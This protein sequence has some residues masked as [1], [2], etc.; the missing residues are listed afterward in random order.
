MHDAGQIIQ[1]DVTDLYS[2]QPRAGFSSL[3]KPSSQVTWASRNRRGH[4]TKH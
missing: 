2:Y 1:K 4:L 3:M